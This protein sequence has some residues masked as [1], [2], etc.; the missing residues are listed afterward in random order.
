MA[1][2]QKSICRMTRELSGV[3]WIMHNLVNIYGNDWHI[4]SIVTAPQSPMELYQFSKIEAM[5]RHLF[6]KG[7]DG[8]FGSICTTWQLA[9]SFIFF[10]PFIYIADSFSWPT[11]ILL[12]W[13]FWEVW[14]HFTS[15]LSQGLMSLPFKLSFYLVK[16]CDCWCIILFTFCQPLNLSV[17]YILLVCEELGQIYVCKCVTCLL[18]KFKLF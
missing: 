14:V 18:Y 17:F 2:R 11:H 7:F 8:T 10:F 4:N 12:H 15:I 1:K 16:K 5:R 13:P 6:T 3:I 9:F